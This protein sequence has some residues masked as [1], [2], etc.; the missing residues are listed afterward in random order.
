MEFYKKGNDPGVGVRIGVQTFLIFALLVLTEIPKTVNAQAAQPPSLISVNSA[1]TNGG[2]EDSVINPMVPRSDISK[3]GRYIVF[4]S[5]ADDL[6]A[7]LADSI[8][9]DVYVRDRQTGTTRI[10]SLNLAGNAPGNADSFSP[11]IS[12]NGKFVAFISFATDLVDNQGNAGAGIFIRDLQNNRTRL[13]TVNLSGTGSLSSLVP[14]L[15]A[16][17][18]DGRYVLFTSDANDLVTNDPNDSTDLFLRDTVDQKTILV[19]VNLAGVASG[20]RTRL[21]SGGFFNFQP[22][23]TPDARFVA[24]RSYANDLVSNDH[25]CVG[26]CDGTNGDSDVFVRDLQTNTTQLASVNLR[27]D[28][29]GNGP[30]S[31][32]SIAADGQRVAFKTFATDL[33][34]N[35]HT[36]Q[37]DIYVRDL[38]AGVTKFVSV[39]LAGDNGGTNGNGFGVNAQVPLISPQGRYVAFTS[40]AV[41]LAPNK[42][43]TLTRDVFVRDLQT[44]TMLLASVN[45]AGTDS[46]SDA[47]HLYGSVPIKFSGD[48]RL[49][50]FSS[51]SPDLVQTDSNGLQDVFV[52][53]LA[54]RTTRLVS[55]NQTGTD[56]PN[57]ESFV[58]DIS[59]D[60]RVVTFHSGATNIVANDTN[61]RFDVFATVIGGDPIGSF[62]IC[63]QDDSSGARLQINSTTGAYQFTSCQGLTLSGTGSLIKRGSVITLQHTDADRRVQATVDTGQHKGSAA[64]RLFQPPSQ[65]TIG[66]RDITN[67]ACTCR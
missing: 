55:L 3:D 1:G 56:S 27:G 42:H 20:S 65:F 32:P 61:E 37:S 30:S 38:G 22:V 52:R 17:S 15:Y 66:D 18:A 57:G 23:M 14:L 9:E 43:D 34:D 44:N 11:M 58:A 59:N 64:I 28:N 45:T 7:G 36:L 6:V 2:N 63:L 51:S 21:T 25:V 26:V 50:L 8:I 46:D 39:N 13:V 60:G 40:T 41:D 31:E 10:V 4:E 35:D 47:N 62:D 19:S 54:A 12:A 24:F 29:S 5:L 48:D 49:L 53:D 16:I 33:V 67:N